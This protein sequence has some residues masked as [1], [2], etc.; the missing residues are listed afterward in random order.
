M[1]W[2]DIGLLLGAALLGGAMNAVA[3][4]GSFFSFPALLLVG[5]APV[6][7]NA[8][9]AVALW[10]A[11]IASMGA[12]RRELGQQQQPLRLMSGLSLVGGA[13]GALL[14]LRTSD[15]AFSRLIPY[16]LLFATVLFAGSNQMTRW[17]RRGISGHVQHRHGVFTIV[18]Q[19]AIAIYGGFFGAGLGIMLLASLALLGLD[20][21]HEMNAVKVL[22]STLIAGVAVLLF[23]FAGAVNWPA[24]LVMVAGSIVGGYGGAALARRLDPR[25]V[26]WFVI[27]VGV[28]LTIYYFVK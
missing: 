7:A 13:I 10:P 5:I 15:T 2:F 26:R 3:G 8:T 9:N 27:T 16:L 28:V 22:L 19:F 24:A 14:L 18:V 12:Y 17:V 21:I 25:R 20:N 6:S 1:T 4:G 11:S 23:A